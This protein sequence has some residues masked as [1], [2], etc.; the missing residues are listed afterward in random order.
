MKWTL[1][2]PYVNCVKCFIDEMSEVPT[3]V[4]SV[5]CKK[6]CGPGNALYQVSS[7]HPYINKL[8]FR[9]KVM[10]SN[11]GRSQS[12]INNIAKRLCELLTEFKAIRSLAAPAKL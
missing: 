2:S 1:S 9:S 11:T 4:A 8:L 6:K 12:R 7:S 5:A 3:V 10:L